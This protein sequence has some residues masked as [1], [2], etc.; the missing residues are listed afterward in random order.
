MDRQHRHPATKKEEA[1]NWIEEV[2]ERRGRKLCSIVA[3][4]SHSSNAQHQYIST[5]RYSNYHRSSSSCCTTITFF[6]PDLLVIG[7]SSSSSSS[8]TSSMS[9][10]RCCF[11]L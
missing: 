2:E 3:E 8:S 9:A 11:L 5:H 1:S 6:F 7:C 10:I 4:V